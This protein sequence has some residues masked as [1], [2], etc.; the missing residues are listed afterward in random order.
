M[1]MSRLKCTIAY[2]GT[3]FFGYQIQPQARTVQEELEK[4]LKKLHKGNEVKITGS[5]RTDA[6]VHAKGQVIHFDTNLKIPIEKW[7]VALNAL[8]P[9]DIAV[10]EAENVDS[11]FH[12]RFDAKGKE[13][14]YFINSSA[15]RDPFTRHFATSFPFALNLKAMQIASQAFIGTH[16]FTSFCSAKTEVVD[17]VRTI[18]EI[19]IYE[20]NGLIVFRFFGNGFLYNMVR[21]LTGTLLEVGIGNRKA[22]TMTEIIGKKDRIHAGKTASAQGLYLWKVFY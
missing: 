7:P 11:S 5:G 2:D 18:N 9:K 10:L 13:Y 6:G 4:A 20:E 12:A 16:D 8:L 15:T 21:I 1:I 17:K 19:D 14:R 3:D 22:E